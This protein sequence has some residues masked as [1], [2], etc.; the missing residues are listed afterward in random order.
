MPIVATPFAVSSIL[1]FSEVVA[2]YAERKIV[3][4]VKDASYLA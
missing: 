3:R 2:A 4:P 1:Q